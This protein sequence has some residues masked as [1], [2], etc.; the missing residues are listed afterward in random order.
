MLRDLPASDFA[1]DEFDVLPALPKLLGHLGFVRSV[2]TARGNVPTPQV[3]SSNGPKSVAQYVRELSVFARFA[4]P[5]DET[6]SIPLICQQLSQHLH[7]PG[8]DTNAGVRLLEIT[9]REDLDKWMREQRVAKLRTKGA[10]SGGGKSAQKKSEDEETDYV[11]S[12]RHSASS[13]DCVLPVIVCGSNQ[14]QCTTHAAVD[15]QASIKAISESLASRLALPLMRRARQLEGATSSMSSRTTHVTSFRLQVC[16]GE[17]AL[18]SVTVIRGLRYDII[19]GKPGIRQLGIVIR[20]LPDDTFELTS[21]LVPVPSPP[22]AIIAAISA[23]PGTTPVSP[24]APA[25]RTFKYVS[26]VDEAMTGVD[27]SAMTP[28]QVAFVRGQFERLHAHGLLL[29]ND[30]PGP[31]YP[32]AN[33]AAPFDIE[34]KE[35]GDL[36]RA[37]AAWRHL[38]PDT[39]SIVRASTSWRP[40]ASFNLRRAFRRRS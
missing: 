16:G 29:G 38:S 13:S 7:A 34:V 4:N 1:F 40:T 31:R 2:W 19:L 3:P 6:A 22:H 24:P 8:P 11:L 39:F 18:A 5:A 35:G 32:K 20:P 26:P 23:T 21:T 9:S 17:V 30:S 15:T 14:L 10:K 25:P 37:F 28:D 36:T 27:T 12:L 33:D